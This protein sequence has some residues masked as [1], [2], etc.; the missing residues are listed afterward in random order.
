MS[1]GR[2][3]WLVCWG[4]AFLAVGVPYWSIA[5][6]S[7]NLPD[8]LYAPGLAAVF[9]AAALLRMFAGAGFARAW[10]ACAAIVPAAVA[11]RI[12]VETARDPTSHNLWPFEI[13]IAAAL[14]LAV[15]LAGAVVG[16][17]LRHAVAR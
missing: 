7:V 5:Y 6:G 12:V 16:G 1:R 13:V 2:G 11:A 3:W 14:G 9:G 17:L 8:A 15:A 10:L 4:M